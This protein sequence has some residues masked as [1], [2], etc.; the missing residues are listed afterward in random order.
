[1]QPK[2]DL[3]LKL[4]PLSSA[5]LPNKSLAGILP[6]SLENQLANDEA[7]KFREI[8]ERGKI[9]GRYGK[10]IK[11]VTEEERKKRKLPASYIYKLKDPSLDARIFGREATLQELKELKIEG[12]EA[13]KKVI[14]FDRLVD[15][16]KL[17]AQQSQLL[18]S[19]SLSI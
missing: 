1:M 11:L 10:G 8:I 9:V 17:Q 14:I 12:V 5:Y 16:H 4:Y 19:N 15:S 2:L 13:Y 6:P 18:K 7:N 3:S